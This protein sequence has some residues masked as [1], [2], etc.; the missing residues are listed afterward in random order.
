[1]IVSRS[2]KDYEPLPLG[3]IPA[4][5]VNYFDLGWQRGYRDKPQ[6]KVVLLFELEAKRNDGTRFL[7]TKKYTASL[8]EKA[9]LLKDLQSWRGVAFSAQELKGFDLD[10]IKGKP[11]QLNLVQIVKGNGD[12][13]V[14]VDAILRPHRSWKPFTPETSPD[15]VPDW[16]LE[17]LEQQIPHDIDPRYPDPSPGEEDYTDDLPF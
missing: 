17:A 14:V 4:I 3:L 9:N 13:Y 12:P 15:F 16:V 7:A 11:C 2:D 5:C 10:A 6:H 1:M 8:G